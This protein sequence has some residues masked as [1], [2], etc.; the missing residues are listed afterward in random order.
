[1]MFCND[2]VPMTAQNPP[3]RSI[4]D[5]LGKILGDAHRDSGAAPGFQLDDAAVD[6]GLRPQRGGTRERRDRC[7]R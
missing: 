5:D 4:I 2:P 7:K 1:M 6:P 3:R